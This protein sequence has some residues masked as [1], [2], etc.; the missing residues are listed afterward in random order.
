MLSRYFLKTARLAS[1]VPALA[2]ASVRE[3]RSRA[4]IHS[5]R[6]A[7]ARDFNGIVVCMLVEA[8]KLL[9]LRVGDFEWFGVRFRE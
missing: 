1:I 7:A 8:W 9:T 3:K 5:F 4:R 6:A 2:V